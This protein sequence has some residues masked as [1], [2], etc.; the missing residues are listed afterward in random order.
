MSNIYHMPAR[1]FSLILVWVNERT[2]LKHQASIVLLA[3]LARRIANASIFA[4]WLKAN[5]WCCHDWAL[6]YLYVLTCCYF[7]GRTQVILW[8]GRVAKLTAPCTLLH[9]QWWALWRSRR[10]S[11]FRPTMSCSCRPLKVRFPPSTL[12]NSAFRYIWIT[13][14]FNAFN[15]HLVSRLTSF[16]FNLFSVSAYDR[17]P[18]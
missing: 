11:R 17:P 5:L 1:R 7:S 3:E 16:S 6:W 2:T 13:F 15:E 9:Q 14:S 10:W 8:V 4:S 18:F 12:R